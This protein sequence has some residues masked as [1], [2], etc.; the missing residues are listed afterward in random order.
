MGLFGGIGKALKGIDW[1]RVSTG[2]SA[3]GASA[4]G[5]HGQAAQIWGQRRERQDKRAENEAEQ[6]QRQQLEAAAVQMGVPPEQASSLPTS[7]LAGI[8]SQKYAPRAPSEFER[9]AQAGG[10]QPGTPEWEQLNRQRANTMASP[11]PQ[12]I[13]SPETGYRWVQPPGMQGQGTPQPQTAASQQQP[14]TYEMYQGAVNSLGEQNAASW[15]QRND[16]VVAVNSPQEAQRLPVGTRYRTP[17]GEE[18]VR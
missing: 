18:Y 6:R 8:V 1:D 17:D 7:A 5:E 14:I 12:M 2:L 13:G 4:H 11:A 16:R 9:S 10:I 3:A 15:V